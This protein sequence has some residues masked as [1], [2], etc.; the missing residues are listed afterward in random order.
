MKKT[1]VYI[2]CRKEAKDIAQNIKESLEKKRYSVFLDIDS[3]NEVST[4]IA[5]QKFDECLDFIPVLSKDSWKKKNEDDSYIKKLEKALNEKNVVPIITRG[6][7]FPSA[8]DLDQSIRDLA[9]RNGLPDNAV[10]QCFDGIMDRLDS[11]FLN[12]RRKIDVKTRYFISAAAITSFAFLIGFIVFG[13][14]SLKKYPTFAK[15]KEDVDKAIVYFTKAIQ[16][17]GYTDKDLFMELSSL[18]KAFDFYMASNEVEFNSLIEQVEAFKAHYL[19][20]WSPNLSEEEAKQLDKTK[21]VHGINSASFTDFKAFEEDFYRNTIINRLNNLIKKTRNKNLPKI[22]PDIPSVKEQWPAYYNNLQKE[23]QIITNFKCH[24]INLLLSNVDYNTKG[25]DG[26]YILHN[27]IYQNYTPSSEVYWEPSQ[28]R[29]LS[30]FEQDKKMLGN[31]RGL[32]ERNE[33]E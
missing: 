13:I 29:L 8:S 6:V 27:F 14:I 20:T 3:E 12:S 17:N 1:Q 23:L 33:S 2:L 21:L 4:V 7:I 10:P 5:K 9:N 31:I 19:N 30:M 18:Y 22:S 24:Y 26:T 28:Q 15:E 25:K 32:L 16:H 11:V